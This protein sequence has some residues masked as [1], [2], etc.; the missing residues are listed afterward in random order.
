MCV[1]TRCVCVRA[2]PP[3]TVFSPCIPLYPHLPWISCEESTSGCSNHGTPCGPPPPSSTDAS[4]SQSAHAAAWEMERSFLGD[5][6]DRGGGCCA[7]DE[8][9]PCWCRKGGALAWA[10]VCAVVVG[11]E[12][13]G[14]VEGVRSC[15]APHS[16]PSSHRMRRKNEGRSCVCGWCVGVRVCAS[17][18]VR[19]RA[20][21]RERERW[22]ERTS[23]T[24]KIHTNNN[25]RV[26][27]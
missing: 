6:G 24:A 9:G 11:E 27:S 26:S 14:R 3:P 4:T 17:V 2:F 23:I 8:V 18:G 1:C 12:V 7:G 20:R 19:A 13:W 5:P 10:S 21:E 25:N 16:S 22:R 15:D